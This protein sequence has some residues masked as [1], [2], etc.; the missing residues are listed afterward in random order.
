[1]PSA[2]RLVLIST[3]LVFACSPADEEQQDSGTEAS[4][5]SAD[6]SGTGDGGAAEAT[7]HRDVRP[8][9]ERHCNAC[10]ADGGIAPFTLGS[11]DEV[12]ELRESLVASVQ[13]GLMPPWGMEAGCGTYVGDSSMV[14]E[15][16][17]TLQAWLDQGAVE[18]DAA[19]F[20]A[21]T[22]IALPE[23]SRT[24]LTLGL[25]EPYLPTQMPDEYR[26]F[27]LDW[28]ETETAFVTG[29]EVDPGNVSIA[30][31]AIAYIAAPEEAEAYEQRDADEPGPGYTCFGGP[32]GSQPLDFITSRWLGAWAPGARVGDLP[33]GTGLRIDPGSKI[34]LQM[35]Y[36][37]LAS[38]GEPDQTQIRYRLESQVE[39]EAVMLPWADPS[40]LAGSMPIPAGTDDTVHSFS[41][42]PTTIIGLLTNDSIADG[43]PL[44]FFSAIH[45]MHKRGSRGL[46]TIERLDGSSECLVDVPRYDYDWQHSYRYTESKVVNPGDLLRLECQWDNTTNDAAVNWGDG[47]NDEMCLGIHYVAAAR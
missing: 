12:Y 29:F 37:T 8:L 36:N 13:A 45:H 47:T 33:E 4:G 6:G 16:R 23:L 14:P 5:D 19:D 31:H 30:H 43:Q 41:M 15:D 26:C 1:M 20:I 28:P 38:D 27:V 18:G 2:R 7:Y 39:R 17:A 34:V 21:P 22:P 10:H 32:A 25:A 46:Q 11:Y 40:W 35:H 24:D 9:L 44:E 42:D 3:A